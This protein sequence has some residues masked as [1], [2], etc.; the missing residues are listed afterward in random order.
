MMRSILQS[1]PTTRASERARRPPPLQFGN[2]AAM[3]AAD[4]EPGLN[5]KRVGERIVATPAAAN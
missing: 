4:E 2:P 5:W 3:G 1:R